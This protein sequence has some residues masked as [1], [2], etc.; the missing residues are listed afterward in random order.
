MQNLL[1]PNVP[2]HMGI[3]PPPPLSHLLKNWERGM[4]YKCNCPQS[5]TNPV[6]AFSWQVKRAGGG[7]GGGGARGNFGDTCQIR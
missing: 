3:S 6:Q 2:K 7:G 4:L 5:E 1:L